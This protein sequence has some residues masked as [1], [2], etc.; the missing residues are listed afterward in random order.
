ML[1]FYVSVSFWLNSKYWV[2]K[3]AGVVGDSHV[4]LIN[5]LW[6]LKS[7]KDVIPRRT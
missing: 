3:L 4:T 7:G 5:L 2:S 1:K 6:K